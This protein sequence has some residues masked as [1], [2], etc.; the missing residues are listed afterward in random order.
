M[1]NGSILVLDFGGPQAQ[2]MARKL[3]GQNYYCEVQPCDID[4]ETVRRKAP[5]GLLLAGGPGDDGFDAEIL[6]LGIPVL[7]MGYCARSMAKRMGAVCEG[8]LLTG[9]ASQI[10]FL[11]CPL[12]D[13]L[14]DS[15]RFFDRIDALQL[16]EGFEPIATTVDGLI[17]AFA[18]LE[19]NLYG[20]QFYAESNDPDGARILGNFAGTI[21][22]C[23]AY[24][25]PEYYIDQEVAYLKDRIG[26]GRAIMAISG[27]VDSTVCAMLMQRVIGDRLRCVFIDTGLLRKGEPEMVAHAF[28]ENLGLEPVVVDAR[29]QMLDALRGITESREKRRV[30]QSVFS[31]ILQEEAAA[32]PGTEFLVEGTIYPDLLNDAA[33]KPGDAERFGSLKR[34][35]PIRMLFKDEVRF[36]GETLGV[37]KELLNRQPFPG[38]GLAVRC[39]GEVNAEK[40]S[41]LREADAI[42]RAEI[43]EAGLDRKLTQYFA[44]LTDMRVA[45]LRD[46]RP[47]TEYACAL[48]AVSSSD[49]ASVTVAK[50]PYDLI[51]RVVQRITSQVPGINHVLYDVTGK[52]TAV[53]EWE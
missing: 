11:P 46:G 27:G 50:L 29:A 28:R 8:A 22:G 53:T 34:I 49:A 16:P 9:R 21:C 48:R 19:K 36:V 1:E 17:P 26:D 41:L 13:G 44:I 31:R 20:L 35:E 45:G 33:T 15:D 39:I 18:N 5:R 51:E 3:R 25:S 32:Y 10:T 38:C 30:I 7:A 23:A 52:P 40:L 37:P 47:S 4:I 6:R 14:G 2:S 12:F 43:V 42:F 24:W